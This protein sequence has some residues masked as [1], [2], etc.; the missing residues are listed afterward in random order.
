M[1]LEW[2]QMHDAK[3]S[4]TPIEEGIIDAASIDESRTDKKQYQSMIGSLLYLA[5][6]TRPDISYSVNVL[7]QFNADPA[8]RHLKAVQRVLRYLKGTITKKLIYKKVSDPQIVIHSDASYGNSADGRKSICGYIGKYGNARVSWKTM[9]QQSTATST[10][11]AEYMAL[12]SACKQALWMSYLL[13]SFGTTLKP[14]L[15]CDNQAAIHISN[16]PVLHQRT[17]HIDIQFHFVREKVLEQKVKL[18]YV[19]TDENEAD[20]FTK[21]LGTVKFE[22]NMGLVMGKANA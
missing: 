20:G 5:I 22:K 17:K 4:K 18:E 1:V 7:S 9:K 6:G 16:N 8:I 15:R 14:R 13:Q 12:S 10:T 11:E 19:S 3:P 21:G 2:F